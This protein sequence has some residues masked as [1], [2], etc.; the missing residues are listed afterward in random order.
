MVERWRVREPFCGWSHLCGVVLSIAGL[1]ALVSLSH[2]KP[3][4]L[5]A[6][7]V[8][9]GSLVLLYTAS[10]LYHSLPVPPQRVQ[11][12]RAFDQVAIYL[13]IAGTYTPLCLVPLRGPW[14]WS[15]LGVIWGMAL[16]GIA[17]RLGWQA[18][19]VW[20]GR[21]LY[22]LMGW[23][24]VAALSPLTRAL[25]GSALGW[26]FFGGILYT[27]GAAVWA[28]RRPRL[29]PGGLSSHELWH[30][31]VLAGSACH[32]VLMVRFVAPAP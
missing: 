11:Q 17:L 32:F 29:W 14:G 24:C 8:Y 28:T 10:T 2:G 3:W 26:L 22:L 16:A 9:G 15:L 6:F 5:T 30:L 1:L 27:V 19:P 21:A 7:L 23:L 4:H 12:L 25:P 20:L 18:A 31:F 13:L